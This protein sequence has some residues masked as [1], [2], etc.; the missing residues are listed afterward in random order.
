MSVAEREIKTKKNETA[1]KVPDSMNDQQMRAG[2]DA[3][4]KGKTPEMPKGL[5][6]EKDK[7]A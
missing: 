7:P 6:L 4:K 3:K 2:L 5:K 1:N